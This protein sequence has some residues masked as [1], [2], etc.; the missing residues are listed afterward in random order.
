MNNHEIESILSHLLGDCFY[1]VWPCD[2]LH[3]LSHIKQR[4]VFLVVNTDPADKP[5]EHWLALTLD[6]FGGASFFDSYGFPPIFQH[7]PKSILNF[8][9]AHSSEIMYHSFQ[10]QRIDSSVCGHHCIF[11]LCH[12]ACGLSMV[13]TL[14]K[15]TT[16]VSKNDSMVYNFVKK[17]QQCRRNHKY[18]RHT[19]STCSLEMFKDCHRF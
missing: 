13:Q 11:Y 2:Q 9:K 1:G 15:Y 12:R 6:K 7:Y 4:P 14:K 3:L 19:Q 17:Y 8:L 5:G 16:D 18:E 10:L